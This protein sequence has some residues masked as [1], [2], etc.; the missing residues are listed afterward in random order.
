MPR[1]GIARPGGVREEDG[2]R[3]A[4]RGERG[5][6]DLDAPVREPVDPDAPG[7]RRRPRDGGRDRADGSGEAELG[8]RGR[9]ALLVERGERAL[10][11][12]D[13]QRLAGVL[14]QTDLLAALYHRQAAAA[15]RKST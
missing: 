6:D 15:A 7:P 11:V 2:D 3:G 10:A 4:E 12:D 14:T 13:A 1:Q 8:R 9:E 5:P